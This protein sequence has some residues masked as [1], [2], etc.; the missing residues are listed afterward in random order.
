[1]IAQRAARFLASSLN[2]MVLG[3]GVALLLAFVAIGGLGLLAYDHLVDRDVRRTVRAEHQD[4]REIHRDAG[5][6]A[7]ARA[8]DAR[9]SAFRSPSILAR[10]CSARAAP[11][12]RAAVA[13]TGVAEACWPGDVAPAALAAASRPM[14]NPREQTRRVARRRDGR[15]R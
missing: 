15:R 4:L 13:A 5:L 2:R 1:M 3:Y 7:L 11:A 6:G 8:I 14:A 12:P 10:G 9:R